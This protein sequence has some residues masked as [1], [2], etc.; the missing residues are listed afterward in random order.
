MHLKHDPYK[1]YQLI[2]KRVISLKACFLCTYP[3]YST[4]NIVIETVPSAAAAVVLIVL[5]IFICLRVRR[6]RIVD[7]YPRLV[8]D[9]RRTEGEVH[10]NHFPNASDGS[11]LTSGS[12][13]ASFRSLTIPSSS[14]SSCND[15][16]NPNK[17]AYFNNKIKTYAEELCWGHQP[18]HTVKVR[19]FPS[20]Q[21]FFPWTF[22]TIHQVLE[23]CDFNKWPL[24]GLLTFIL[25]YIMNREIE[26]R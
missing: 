8:G 19:K 26:W 12:G 16:T 15:I 7:E 24:S 18:Y 25:F 3:G 23:N 20:T 22:N 10:Q 13:S 5:V 4:D 6:R 1:D 17:K 9:N 14:G 21:W 11:E 2:G